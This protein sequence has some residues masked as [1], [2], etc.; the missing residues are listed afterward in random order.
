MAEIFNFPAREA[1]GNG[2]E[3]YLM[4]RECLALGMIDPFTKWIQTLDD[5]FY[6]HPEAHT[7]RND[8][9][10]SLL[11]DTWLMFHMSCDEA[12]QLE[13]KQYHGLRWAQLEYHELS[14]FEL[15]VIVSDNLIDLRRGLTDLCLQ[16]PLEGQGEP[17]LFGL[18]QDID[19]LNHQLERLFYPRFSASRQSEWIS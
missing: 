13:M 7:R 6:R 10:R 2:M 5:W 15:L 17:S 16:S 9:L 14:D 1:H 3:R 18:I 12:G 8:T 11:A 4:A 19:R